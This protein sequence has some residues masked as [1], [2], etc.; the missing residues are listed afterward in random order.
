[1]YDV[2]IL[3]AGPSGS[4]LARLLSD[5]NYKT[6]LIEKRAL[7]EASDGIKIKSC[8]GLLAPAAQRMLAQLDIAIPKHIV[9]SPQ[10]YSVQ[11][12][13]FDNGVSQAYNRHYLNI[14]REAFDRYL[15]QMIPS[16][17][18]KY[19]GTVVKNIFV[20]N[21]IWHVEA[22]NGEKPLVVQSKFL[23]IADGAHS[24]ARRKL[25]HTLKSPTLYTSIQSIHN[26]DEEI[27]YYTGFFDSSVTDYYAWTIQKDKK[28][29]V[30]AAIPSHLDVYE[31]FDVIE[32]KILAHLNLEG[33]K[34]SKV[35]GA[36]INRTTHLNQLHWSGCKDHAPYAL[37][38]EAAGATSPTSAE[39]ISYALKSSLYLYEALMEDFEK[40]TV[41]YKK[42]CKKI[43]A[44]LWLKLLKSPG[45]YHIKLRGLVMKTG[46]TAIKKRPLLAF[47][48]IKSISAQ[49][50]K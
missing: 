22:Y 34:R 7:N 8:G 27:P 12:I 1:M 11:T 19:I 14:N 32:S 33:S 23:V 48:R 20:D 6:C 15:Y 25:F 38:G 10:M 16:T 21:G 29:I 41:A 50:M 24:F 31:R 28:L 49:P 26:I 46:I 44:N 36:F 4:N 18:V 37:V 2:V 42:R 40:A 30:G 39:G 45:M 43:E 47:K 9:E 5:S 35:E 17:V 13:D 3:G